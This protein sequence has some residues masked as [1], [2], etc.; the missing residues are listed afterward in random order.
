MLY[1]NPIIKTYFSKEER[2]GRRGGGGEQLD[3]G[4]GTNPLHAMKE[5][6]GLPWQTSCRALGQTPQPNSYSNQVGMIS[7]VPDYL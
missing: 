6:R 1:Q 4:I 5:G 2:E 3:R 7:A